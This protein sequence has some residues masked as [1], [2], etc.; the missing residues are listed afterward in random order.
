[1]Y[2]NLAIFLNGEN[3]ITTCLRNSIPGINMR[4]LKHTPEETLR[5]TFIAI[6]F[7]RVTRKK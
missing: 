6:Q 7:I 4:T 5:Q 2:R 3:K 1:L